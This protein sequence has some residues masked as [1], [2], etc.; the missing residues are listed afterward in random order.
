MSIRQ[1]PFYMIIIGSN[2][3]EQ[4]ITGDDSMKFNKR[5]KSFTTLICIYSL[6]VLPLHQCTDSSTPP[7]D[8]QISSDIPE[9]NIYDFFSIWLQNKSKETGYQRTSKPNQ[10]TLDILRIEKQRIDDLLLA[11]QQGDQKQTEEILRKYIIDSKQ[12]LLRVLNIDPRD[13]LPSNPIVN[14]IYEMEDSLLSSFFS[15][16]VKHPSVSHQTGKD[17]IERLEEDQQNYLYQLLETFKHKAG[18]FEQSIRQSQKIIHNIVD[19]LESPVDQPKIDFNLTPEEWKEANQLNLRS[20]ETT[21]GSLIVGVALIVLLVWYLLDDN[22][23]DED[24]ESKEEEKEKNAVAVIYY[25]HADFSG[26]YKEALFE[27]EV[28][29]LDDVIYVPEKCSS[30]MFFLGLCRDWDKVITSLKVKAGYRIHLYSLKEGLGT[31]VE[32]SGPFNMNS[33]TNVKLKGQSG[34]FN[35]KASSIKMEKCESCKVLGGWRIY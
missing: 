22:D 8:P 24:S 20:S 5:M 23:E 33:L 25:Q 14:I 17:L 16:F 4:E 1:A 29:D 10:A 34:N 19:H 31:H 27:K 13:M 30:W 26:N 12:I 15:S 21:L 2:Q 35:D 11:Y 3:T 32:I 18:L 7:T 6:L 28:V 9:G